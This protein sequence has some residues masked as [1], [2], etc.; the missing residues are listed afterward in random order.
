MAGQAQRREAAPPFARPHPLLCARPTASAQHSPDGL[1][2]QRADQSLHWECDQG[3][4][5]ERSQS[6]MGVGLSARRGPCG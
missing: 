1:Q 6:P 4:L 5:T 2:D 3:A